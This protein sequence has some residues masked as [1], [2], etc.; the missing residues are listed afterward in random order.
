MKNIHSSDLEQNFT[1]VYWRDS[2]SSGGT[3]IPDASYVKWF[4]QHI[5]C[6]P[7]VQ[8]NCQTSMN[9]FS[10]IKVLKE[11]CGIY[12]PIVDIP[13]TGEFSEW[14]R[15]FNLKTKFSFNDYLELINLIR[16]D[17][18]NFPINQERIQNIY[19]H[20]FDDCMSWTSD[21]I[22]TVYLLAENNQWKLANELYIY[23]DGND[24]NSQLNDMIPCL[25][26][27]SKNRKD[28]N[29]S[30]FARLFGIQEIKSN[31]LRVSCDDASHAEEFREKL[32][33]ISPYLKNWLRK[34][35]VS[36]ETIGSIDRIVQQH[37]RF[38]EGDCLKLYYHG[39]FIQE[40]N[41]YF[42]SSEQDFYFTRPW[43]SE[44]TLIDLPRKLCR[45]LNIQGFEENLRFL[46][47]G[48]QTE[49]RTRFEKL[50]IKL[51]TPEDVVHLELLARTGRKSINLVL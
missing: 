18:R 49:I 30:N 44:T 1:K 29:L 41:A 37:T 26:L 38:I 17:E 20:L 32:I 33:E 19:S 47:K 21:R 35:N 40:T 31:D 5:P 2:S 50:S 15:F 12:L 13:T 14:N 8:K 46:L 23:I 42:D 16:A 25:K 39:K 43:D 11:L 22:Q 45:L 27:N 10:N 4:I 34:Q 7:T 9:T 3:E 48:Q 28:P 36:L 24:T 6:I 51:P